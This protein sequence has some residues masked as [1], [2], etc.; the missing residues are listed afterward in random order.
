MSKFVSDR[1]Q[2]VV[3]LFLWIVLITC[4]LAGIVLGISLTDNF[5]GLIIGG[6]IGLLTGTFIIVIGGGYI[7]TIKYSQKFR[8]NRQTKQF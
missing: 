6:V 5:I 4:A 1:F 3:S 8:I 7:A 2:E